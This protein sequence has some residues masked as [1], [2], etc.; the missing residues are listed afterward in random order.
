MRALRRLVKVGWTVSRYRLDTLLEGDAGADSPL[1]PRYRWLLKASPARLIPAGSESR[2][3]RLR[4]ALEQLGPVFIKFGQLLSTRRDLLPRDIADELARLQDHVPPFS[5]AEA[6]RIVEQ[7]I[8]TPIEEAFSYFELDP[9][10]SAS[11]A[12]VHAASLPDGTRVVVKVVRPGIDRIIREDLELL[13]LLAAFLDEHSREAR[14]LHLPEVVEDYERTILQELDLQQ[15]AANT[16]RLRANFAESPLLYVPR[17]YWHLTRRNVLVLERIDGVPIGDMEALRAHGTDL[18]KLADRGVETFFTQVF[19][20][21]FFHADMHPGNIFVD[22]TDP[23][24]PSYIAI[25]CAIIGSLTREDQDYLARNLLAFFNRD[26]AEV[27]RLHLESGWIPEDTDPHAFERVI[28]E[29]CEPIFAK[30]LNEISFG[31][32]LVQLFDTAREF[33]MEIQPQLVLL[34]KTLLY[35]EGLG[36]ELYP[37]LDLWETAKPFMERWVADHVGPAAALREF[38]EYAPLILDQLPRLP[39]LVARTGTQL[40]QLE[41][42]VDRQNDALAALDRRLTRL[43]RRWRSRRVAGGALIVAAGVLLWGPIAESL[44]GD[45]GLGAVAGLAS[46]AVGSLLL[47]RP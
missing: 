25:D 40:R 46:A 44:A 32:F 35:I 20:H 11:V 47:L 4:M 5:G 18:K 10:A 23:A 45:A 3:A 8:G 42:A 12:Q 7:A 17:V 9:M 29:L 16:A 36:R 21:N 41:R 15:E 34:Q 14:R 19:E 24:D 28:K 13:R 39:A 2:G 1:P 38:A 26:Y 33:D 27:A 30:P 43:D 22:V 31:L 6:R 37:Q